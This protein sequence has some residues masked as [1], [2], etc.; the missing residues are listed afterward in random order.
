MRKSGRYLDL[1]VNGYFGIDFHSDLLNA[2]ELHVV[3]TAMARD[4]VD[5]FLATITTEHVPVMEH[6]LRRLVELREANPLARAMIPALHIEGPFISALDGYRGAHPRDAVRPADVDSMKRLLDAAGGLASLVTLAP[7]ND[8]GLAVTRYLAGQGIRVS[9]GHTNAS[10]EQLRA[11]VDAGLSMFTHLGNGCPMHMHRHD[12][13]IQRALSLSDRLFPMFIAD[14]AHVAFPALG[15]YLRTAGIDRCIVVTDAVAPAGRGPGHFRLGR[16]DLVVGDDLVAR[17]P[18]GSHLIGSA[19]AM[20]RAVQN[21]VEEVG[22]TRA[23]AERLTAHNPR[24]VMGYDCD[25]GECRDRGAGPERVGH[26]RADT[27]TIE[28]VVPGR[29][30]NGQPSGAV[31]GS[32]PGVG[33]PGAR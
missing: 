16:W 31:P 27:G 3:C 4:G 30:R 25:C 19:V 1:Q 12:N 20:P 17:A 7:E 21:L 8:P 14:G 13:I 18:D 2:E 29:G 11:A 5:G 26:P 32:G 10:L 24:K 23:E 22:L 9:A 6:R 28:V 33:V 15:N